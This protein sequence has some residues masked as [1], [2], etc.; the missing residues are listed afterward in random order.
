M[1]KLTKKLEKIFRNA[2]PT[3]DTWQEMAAPT[4]TVSDPKPS[5]KPPKDDTV[6]QNAPAS[7]WP[8]RA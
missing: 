3:G 1:A 4:I 7:N 5:G 8:Y 2:D 6:R